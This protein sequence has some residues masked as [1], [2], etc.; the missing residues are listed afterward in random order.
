MKNKC[1]TCF[2]YGLHYLGEPTP[3]G[4]IDA[5]DG[6]PTIPCPECKANANPFKNTDVLEE[7]ETLFVNADGKKLN[8]IATSFMEF[9]ESLGIKFVDVT[10]KIK[11]K[12]KMVNQD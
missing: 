4:P 5:S 8:P 9:C 7:N 12:S 10:D 6:Y 1:K 2:G 11:K 3:V